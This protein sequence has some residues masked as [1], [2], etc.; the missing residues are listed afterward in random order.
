MDPAKSEM[1]PNLNFQPI[2]NNNPRSLNSF[3]EKT[4]LQSD[5]DE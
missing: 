1:Y 5:R 3:G 4:H 2:L